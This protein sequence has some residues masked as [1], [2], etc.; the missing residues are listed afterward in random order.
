MSKFSVNQSDLQNILSGKKQD[1]EQCIK[2]A[3]F[4]VRKRGK[5]NI[6]AY[7]LPKETLKNGIENIERE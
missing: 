4:C 5:I 1:L 7:F 2:D 3:N 6:F